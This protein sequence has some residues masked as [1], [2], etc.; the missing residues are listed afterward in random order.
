M[1]NKELLEEK[2]RTDYRNGDFDKPN[3]QI[4]D[5]QLVSDLKMLR[6]DID[7]DL[8]KEGLLITLDLIIGKA[9]KSLELE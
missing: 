4:V 8:G 2:M 3:E 6:E 9:E 1:T 7:S 5:A